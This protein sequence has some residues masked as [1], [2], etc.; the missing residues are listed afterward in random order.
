M[1][2]EKAHPLT[3]LIFILLALVLAL[4]MVAAGPAQAAVPGTWTPTG[5]LISARAYHT[6]V[7]LKD[8]R[9]LVAGGMNEGG[10]VLTNCEIYDPATETWT[11]AAS[12]N[13]ARALHTATRLPRRPG[14]AGRRLQLGRWLPDRLRDL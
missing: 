3:G 2:R 4:S 5:N 11:A 7:G 1:T 8:G 12:L 9:V 14:P 6:A 10:I 13:S